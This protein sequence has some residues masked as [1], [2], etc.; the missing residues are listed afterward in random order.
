MSTANINQVTIQQ[1]I[2]ANFTG[3]ELASL[4]GYFGAFFETGRFFS[5][6]VVAGF[7]GLQST[8]IVVISDGVATNLY[9]LSYRAWKVIAPN[10][11]Q[12]VLLPQ[13]PVLGGVWGRAP[14]EMQQLLQG[15]FLTPQPG[16]VG[17]FP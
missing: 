11:A 9:S 2:E 15:L 1:F 17:K 13:Q 6:D 5:Q 8:A 14:I 4:M 16:L 12:S 10:Y 3:P 7:T